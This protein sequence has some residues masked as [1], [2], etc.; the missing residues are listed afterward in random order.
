MLPQLYLLTLRPE[1]PFDFAS[2]DVGQTNFSTRLLCIDKEIVRARA[3]AAAEGRLDKSKEPFGI[4]LKQFWPLS[5][6]RTLLGP[7]FTKESLGH[8]PD[9]LI[10]QPSD[11]VRV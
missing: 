9:G 3:Q 7:K 1:T 2:Q 11:V 5:D 6:T 8:E 10:F 4:R